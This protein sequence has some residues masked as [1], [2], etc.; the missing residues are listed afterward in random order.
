VQ[1]YFGG[2]LSTP[3]SSEAE[4]PIFWF[5]VSRGG[6]MLARGKGS[7]P[8]GFD[9]KEM[10]LRTIPAGELGPPAIRVLWAVDLPYP[11][12]HRF[13]HTVPH[14]CLESPAN[15]L[16]EMLPRRLRELEARG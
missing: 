8:V 9:G 11:F 13:L 12:L 3:P 16:N 1:Q 7:P 14:R 2:A 4:S 10:T 6:Q 15:Y 5:S